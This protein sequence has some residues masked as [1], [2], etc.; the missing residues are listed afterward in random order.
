MVFERAVVYFDLML[1]SS[2]VASLYS[3]SSLSIQAERLE[4]RTSLKKLAPCL[5]EL[6]AAAGWPQLPLRV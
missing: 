6:T 4:E 1:A 3:C 2:L 5:F